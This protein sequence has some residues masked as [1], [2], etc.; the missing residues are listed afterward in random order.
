MKRLTKMRQRQKGMSSF[1]WIAVAGIFGFLVITF[2]KVFPFY[3]D[4]FK[5]TTSLEALQLDTTIDAKSKRAIW[6]S[7]QKRLFINEVRM[8]TREHVTMVRKDGKTTVTV[9]YEQKDDYIGNLFIG[10][11]FVES[12]VIDR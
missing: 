4:N 11:E 10:G 3:Y 2:F 1:G 6:E 12:I 9:T 8:I 7:L 5:L